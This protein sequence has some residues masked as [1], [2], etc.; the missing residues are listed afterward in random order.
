MEEDER[1]EEGDIG[2]DTA[3]KKDIYITNLTAKSKITPNSSQY[4]K[5][6]EMEEDERGEE[7]WEGDIRG[8]TARKKDIYH[9]SYS[10]I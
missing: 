4:P 8:D 1:G 6:R 5:C 3:Q 9:K 7:G 10:K 2:S